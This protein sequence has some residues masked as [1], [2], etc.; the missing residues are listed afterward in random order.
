MNFLK[1]VFDWMTVIGLV[2]LLGRIVTAVF[3]FL[4]IPFITLFK[5]YSTISF[6]ILIVGVIGQ[7]VIKDK[8]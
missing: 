6:I 4:D 5:D 3:H 7:Q 8:K 2:L 1:I